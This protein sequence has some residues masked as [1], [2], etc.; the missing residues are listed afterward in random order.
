MMNRY[1]F[2]ETKEHPWQI[3]LTQEE[4]SEDGV[5]KKKPKADFK[6]IEDNAK[7]DL[8]RLKQDGFPFLFNMTIDPK[9]IVKDFVYEKLKVFKS[10]KVPMMLMCQNAQP[11]GNPVRTMFKNGDDL[12]QDI[13]TLQI[14]SVMDKIWLQNNMD[15]KMTPYKVIGTHCMQGYLEFVPDCMTLA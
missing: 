15:L 14:I 12:R 13:L 1:G 11:G 8:L 4:K 5:K 9:S 10:K 6:K 7:M 3:D 2:L